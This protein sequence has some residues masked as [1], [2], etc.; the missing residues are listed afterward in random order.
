MLI[1]TLLCA[2]VLA[3]I[4]PTAR[5]AIDQQLALNHIGADL[6]ALAAPPA[7]RDPATDAR[8]HKLGEQARQ[9]AVAASPQTNS[10]DSDKWRS[11]ACMDAGCGQ[12]SNENGGAQ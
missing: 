4:T 1:K 10:G 2:A 6:V 8:L 12:P 3:A 11:L 9:I 5:H 7:L